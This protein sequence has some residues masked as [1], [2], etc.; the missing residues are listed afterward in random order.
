MGPAAGEFSGAGVLVTLA[1][2][3]KFV[4]AARNAEK[5]ELL[6]RYH[7]A[8]ERLS[9]VILTGDTDVDAKALKDATGGKGAHAFVDYSPSSLKEE[10]PFSMAGIKS[11]KRGGEYI[12][13]GG[14][15]VDLT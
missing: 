8:K 5:L 6:E 4:T 2:G 9:T 11:F 7:G 13:L 12:L 15:Y 3:C 14:A 1:M 10:P